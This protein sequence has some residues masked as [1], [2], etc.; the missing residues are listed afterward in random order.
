MPIFY[1][2]RQLHTFVGRISD[3]LGA[4]FEARKEELTR[5][6]LNRVNTHPSFREVVD[7]IDIRDICGLVV[8]CT[9][10]KFRCQGILAVI[11]LGQTLDFAYPAAGRLVAHECMI[12]AACR[13]KPDF[14]RSLDVRL[15][16]TSRISAWLIPA[17]QI[18]PLE[19]MRAEEFAVG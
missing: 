10:K 3:E 15:R 8:E 6:P 1:E 19:S 5:S 18:V 7:S 12:Q 2:R 11:E 14:Y 9:N 17:S 4:G 16:D 13:Q